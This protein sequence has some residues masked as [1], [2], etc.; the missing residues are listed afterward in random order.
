[1]FST[2]R[3]NTMFYTTLIPIS[4]TMMKTLMQE[5]FYV[6]KTRRME[7]SPPFP[8]PIFCITLWFT[9]PKMGYNYRL[10]STD[11]I[12]KKNLSYAN[13]KSHST[14]WVGLIISK[15]V[16]FSIWIV[17]PIF[18]FNILWWKVLIGFLVMHYTAGLILSW[19]SNWLTLL[20]KPI[21][22][23]QTRNGLY[24]KL[25]GCSPTQTTVNFGNRNKL[26]IGL[27]EA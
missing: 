13:S 10:C 15:I 24:E 16:Y 4:K 26:S 18:V 7:T 19:S 9:D 22:L 25:L 17:L 5:W 20:V 12:P 8:T 11:A 14:Q 3:C 27:Q 23:Y 6:F 1:M 21:C 2:G